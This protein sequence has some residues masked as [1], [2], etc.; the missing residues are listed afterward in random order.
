MYNCERST[1][2]PVNLGCILSV[3][4]R[5]ESFQRIFGSVSLNIFLFH[6]T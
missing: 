1:M 4:V 2:D 6:L 3:D 5:V